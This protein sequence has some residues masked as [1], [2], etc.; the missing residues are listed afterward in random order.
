MHRNAGNLV[1]SDGSVQAS[2]LTTLGQLRRLPGPRTH[3]LV[4]P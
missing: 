1:L 2:P 3:R 4:V